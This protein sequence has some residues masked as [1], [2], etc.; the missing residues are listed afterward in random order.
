MMTRD[1]MRFASRPQI[2]GKREVVVVVV[3]VA[4]A[5]EIGERLREGGRDD[6]GGRTTKDRRRDSLAP[7]AFY[8]RG[9]RELKLL[10][11]YWVGIAPKCV[12]ERRRRGPLYPSTH[13][14]AE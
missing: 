2:S 12:G 6:G 13:S 10:S 14:R 11:D 1:A 5:H 9:T 7:P 8:S 4:F 3:V